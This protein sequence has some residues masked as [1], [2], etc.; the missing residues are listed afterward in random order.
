MLFTQ[1]QFETALQEVTAQ[2]SPKILLPNSSQLPKIPLYL[3]ETLPSTNQTLWEILVEGAT[4]PTLVI[5][6]QQTAGRGQ[7]GRQW[8]SEIGGLYLSLALTLKLQANHSSQLTF[9]SAWGIAR[10]LREYGIPVFLKWPNDLILK[11]KKLGGI[12]TETRVQQG[13]ITQAVVGVGINWCNCPPETGISLESFCQDQP[14]AK[15]TS[16]AIV[17]AIVLYGLLAG[18]QF[19]LEEGLEKLRLFYQDL[20]YRS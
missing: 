16:L 12:L 2:V 19:S 18:Y 7:W 5:A 1:P 6:A 8:Q 3:F 4:P 20:L 15:I 9:C 11:D 14:S 13:Y 10:V 17:A